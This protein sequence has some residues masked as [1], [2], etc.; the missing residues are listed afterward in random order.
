LKSVAEWIER[1]RRV[2]R[3]VFLLLATLNTYFASIVWPDS[4][5]LALSS[6]TIAVVLLAAAIAT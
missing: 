6:A 3:I 2:V 4:H 5:M 1:H